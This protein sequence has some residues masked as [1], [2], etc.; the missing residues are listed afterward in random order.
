M[1]GGLTYVGCYAFVTLHSAR[2]RKFN[3]TFTIKLRARQLQ[4][5]FSASHFVT[6]FIWL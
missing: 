4:K 1:Q 5:T 2:S 6:R 3:I